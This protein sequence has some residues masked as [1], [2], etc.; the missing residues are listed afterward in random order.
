M[1]A[2]RRNRNWFFGLCLVASFLRT[3]TA[4]SSFIGDFH[5]IRAVAS[6]VP[7]NGDVNPYGVAV[8][9]VT[10]GKL[11]QGDI[12]VSNFNNQG[13]N[14]GTG[15]TIVQISPNGNVDLFAQID[16]GKL[17]GACPG[18]VGLTTALVVLRSG[19]VIVGSLPT[20]NGQAATAQ[21]GC[22]IVL[23]DQGQP[24]KTLS[25]GSINGPWDMT[26][27][28][29]GNFAVLFVTNVLNGTV[30]AGGTIVNGG[31]V[32]RL[33]LLLPDQDDK[34]ADGDKDTPFELARTVI[35]SGF[36]ER[37]DPNALVIGPTGVGLGHDG[38]LYVA[39]TLAN[40]IA[41]IPQALFRITS[42]GIGTTV[43]QGGSLKG[44]LGLAIAPNQDILTVNSLDGNM[45]ETTPAGVQ[46][47]VQ[48]LDNTAVM[49]PGLNGSGALFGL[50]V[51]PGG[52]GVYFVD[53]NTNTLNELH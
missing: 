46:V 40:R 17:P 53:D 30:A 41:A 44:P 7:T 28:D 1:R 26:A 36:G 4:A 35:A 48:T 50:A 25:G 45:A 11:V 19:W 22:L 21:A 10:K 42:A 51:A 52:D 18:G 14:Q 38:T 15:T 32:V 6:T 37:T 16:A 23:N 3:A 34:G 27:F 33:L 24:V 8:S 43:S 20:S 49:P 13:N 31:T 29:G 5:N 39:D 47:A 2:N 9:P 12:L